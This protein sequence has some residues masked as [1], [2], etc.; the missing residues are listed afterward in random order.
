MLLKAQLVV[1]HRME[2]WLHL[3]LYIMVQYLQKPQCRLVVAVQI[4]VV[5]SLLLTGIIIMRWVGMPISK[6]THVIQQMRIKMIVVLH[7]VLD[8]TTLGRKIMVSNIKNTEH[9]LCVFKFQL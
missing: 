2:I 8:G 1:F 7:G 5:I 6:D 4:L 3:M 9:K